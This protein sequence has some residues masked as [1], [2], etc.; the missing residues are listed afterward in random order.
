MGSQLLRS[1]HFATC[2]PCR[3]SSL[4]IKSSLNSPSPPSPV[5]MGG[6]ARGDKECTSNFNRSTYVICN[7]CL[8][9]SRCGGE[10]VGGRWISFSW[11]GFKEVLGSRKPGHC[12]VLWILKPLSFIWKWS[13][14]WAHR[15]H[16]ICIP[17]CPIYPVSGYKRPVIQCVVTRREKREFCG[18][19]P[20]VGR[21]V[22]VE[23]SGE[24]NQPF[25]MHWG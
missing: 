4:R 20:G 8:F 23:G 3:E 18:V 15:M 17:T 1:F 6:G 25:G 24:R 10:G 16:I 21:R 19:Q 11:W 14:N 5:G 22:G 9:G 7:S 13:H 2:G 12:R